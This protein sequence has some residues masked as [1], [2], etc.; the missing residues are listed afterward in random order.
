M[1]ISD[2]APCTCRAGK[3]LKEILPNLLHVTCL[4][5]LMHNCAKAKT[6]LNEVDNLIPTVKARNVLKN[7]SRA[8]DFDVC[9]KPPQ[10]IVTRW[11]SW[12]NAANLTTMLRNFRKCEKF[13]I[14]GMVKE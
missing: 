9:G 3:V 8:A 14:H 2:T 12:L 13:L 5:H 6:F 4:A 11:G 10:P 7:I 1:L